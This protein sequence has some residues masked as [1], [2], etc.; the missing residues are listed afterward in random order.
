M[1]TITDVKKVTDERW[2]NLFS[3]EYTLENGKQGSWLFASRKKNP[4]LGSNPTKADAVVVIPIHKSG[5]LVMT[6]EFRIPIQN[7]EYG[8]P[9]GLIDDEET[10]EG[11]AK[12]ELFEETGLI[13]TKINLI[14]P[15]VVS[16]AGLSDES[17]I[18]VFCECEG[19]PSSQNLQDVE[20]IE[21]LLV[22]KLEI[23]ALLNSNIAISA[24]AWP[25]I[26]SYKK[27]GNLNIYS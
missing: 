7:Y 27:E 21:T 3:A 26:M 16:S 20:N 13:L 4:E 24:K 17:V 19:T 22:N 9:A 6:K 23:S 12:R 15:P 8:F 18:L 2:I 10:I 25:F 5:K 1:V 14:S 11:C